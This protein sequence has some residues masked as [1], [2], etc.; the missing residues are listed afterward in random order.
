MAAVYLKNLVL[1]LL[2]YSHNAGYC[3]EDVGLSSHGVLLSDYIDLADFRHISQLPS[4]CF[5]PGFPRSDF[6]FAPSRPIVT[7]AA[8]ASRY[9]YGYLTLPTP[10]IPLPMTITMAPGA[11]R[12]PNDGITKP[13]IFQI[14]IRSAI[15]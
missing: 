4:L 9:E 7:A 11:L 13:G 2:S 14:L 15:S 12:F 5:G 1:N 3:W 10:T 6:T 8:K